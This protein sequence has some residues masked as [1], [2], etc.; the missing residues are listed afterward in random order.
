MASS[1]QGQSQCWDQEESSGEPGAVGAGEGGGH[2][3][4]PKLCMGWV[5]GVETVPLG[6]WGKKASDV[7]LWK[8]KP[9]HATLRLGRQEG[10][11]LY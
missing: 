3:G 10:L 6:C 11:R 7:I 4:C 5:G 2:R 1:P 9:Q 8:Q